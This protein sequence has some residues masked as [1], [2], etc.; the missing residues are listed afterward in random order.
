MVRTTISP[1]TPP[2]AAIAQMFGI[3]IVI[4]L[5]YSYFAVREVMQVLFYDNGISIS[6]EE[7]E[8]IFDQFFKADLAR[9]R[10]KEGNGL[11]LSR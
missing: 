8:R 10:R 1:E 11:G 4:G 2:C 9:D 6:K 3:P 7:Q 5:I